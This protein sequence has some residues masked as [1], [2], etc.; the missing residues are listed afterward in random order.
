[1]DGGKLSPYGV[2]IFCLQTH[3]LYMILA[4]W[5]AR[6]ILTLCDPLT[7][8]RGLNISDITILCQEDTT[9]Y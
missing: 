1:M 9:S 2:E 4:G 6:I 3:H 7:A 5:L 8:H